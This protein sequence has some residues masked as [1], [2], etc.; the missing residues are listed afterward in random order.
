[1]FSVAEFKTIHHS[2]L[3]KLLTLTIIHYKKRKKKHNDERRELLYE[4]V[5][6]N[7]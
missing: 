1:M 2:V 4:V 6:S 7:F 5:K 3:Y